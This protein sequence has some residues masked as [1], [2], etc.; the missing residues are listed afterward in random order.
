ME[1]S[2]SSMVKLTASNYSIWKTR[3]EDVLYCKDLFDPIEM[4]GVKP[5]S[6]TNEDWNKMNRKAVGYI[7]QW[8]D[9]SVFHHVAK[10]VDAYS[11]WQK[12]ESLYERKTAQNKAFVIRRLVNLKYKDGHSV[13]EHLSN[14]QGLLNDLSTMKLA[15]DDEVQAL[16]LLSSLPDSWETLV[17]SLSNSAPSGV[18]TMSMVKDSMFNE[19]ARRKEQGI[20]SQSEALVTEK[21]GRSKSRKPRKYDSRD[22]SKGK[23]CSRSDIKCFFCGKLGHM[24]REC[25][26]FKKEQLK[27]KGEEQKEEKDTAAVA[28][29]GDVVIAFDE[30]YAN[31][32]CDESRWVVDTAA[33]F[34][35]TPHRDFFSSY[36]NGHFGWV[37]M[38]NEAKCKIVGMGD[39]QLET[40]IGCKLVLK[41]VRHVPEMRFNLISIWKLDD[42]GYHNY[43]GGGQWKLSKGSLSLAKGKK[44]SSLYKTDARLVKGDAVVVENENSTELWHKRLGHM[45]E[46][47]LQILAKEQLLPNNKGMSLTPCTHCLIGKQRRVS[48]Q[49]SSSSRKENILDLVHTDVCTMNTKTLG[50]ALYYV[51][52]IDDHSRKVWV[53]A[54]KTKDQVLDVFKVFHMKVERETGKQLKCVRAD[55]GGEYRGPF[56]EYCRSHGIRLEKT[57]PKTPQHN[58]VAERMNRT[59]CE[60]IRCMLS[61]AKLP[62]PFWG[63]AMRTAVDLINLSPSV[64]LD[65]D[66]P[67]RVWTGKDVSFEHL[68]VFGCRAFVHIPRDERSK[69]DSKVKQ[70]IFMGYGHEEFGYRLWDPVNKKIIR[71][72]DVVFFE[73]QTIE[74]LDQKKEESL[75]KYCVDLGPVVPTYVMHD[76]H[77][78]DVQ[79]EHVDTVGENGEPTIDNVESEEH[80]EQASSEPTTETQLRRSTRDRQPSRKYSANEYVLLSDRGEPE[81]YQDAMQ[82]D[83]KKQWLEA[84]QD[85]MK[86]LHENHTY[87]LVKLPKGKRAL[88][89]K[90][91]FRCKIEPN[92]SQP[93]YKARLVVKGFSQKKGIDFDEIFSPVVKMSSIRVVLS[94]AA[95]MNL[96]IE[97]LDV[98]TAFLHGDLEEEIYMEQPEGFSAKGKEHL[99]C[100]LK[101][102]LYG[103]KQ[104]PRLWYKKFDSFMVDHGYDRTTS[105]HC[106][107][108]KKFSDGEFIILLLYVDDMLIVGRDTSKIDKLKKELSKSFS[109]KDLGSAK[110][111]LGMKISRD[112]KSEKLWLS[113]ES[114]IEKVLDRFNMSKAK[115]VSSTLAGHLKLSS[116]QS[117]TSEEE[118]EEMK[119][120]PYASAVGSLMYAMVCTRPDIAHAVGVV[121]RFL[122][123]P[124]KEHWAAV[125]WILRYLRGTSRVCLCFGNGKQVLDGFT[126]ADMAGDIDS[127]KST[128]GYLITYSGGAVSWQSRL[129]KCVALST[130]EAEYIAITEAAKELL[131]MKKFLQELGLQQERYVLYC[132]SQSAIHLSKNSTFH[133]RSKHIDVRYHWI[134]DALDE[135]LIH[136]EKIHTDDNGSDMMTKSLPMQKL[137]ICRI[138]AGLV[139]P[140]T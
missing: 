58:G 6:T 28:L 59:I 7:R 2:S 5:I 118:K 34:H 116:K 39:I 86:S 89:N 117:P 50:G 132:D 104:A 139:E 22:K 61:H 1:E 77:T 64:P 72:R 38:G 57:V 129:Q 32:T 67:Q 80:L 137:E 23:S 100:R 96:E 109:M 3:M 63:E 36:T 17:V 13:T 84:M 102:S 79:E 21:R 41:D 127:R 101:K 14:F 25:R 16:L 128:S 91:V 66:I 51:T 55:N 131:W 120:V 31:I 97:Q 135:K 71:S 19:E 48:F 140:P 69:L 56:E 54:L 136:I 43:L 88:K 29:D 114:Y 52:F 62:K 26:K 93:R 94:L 10:E 138:A 78:G 65:G 87:D 107:F 12:L 18:I 76:E 95:K 35:I 110:Q 130:T 105:D 37:R 108:V 82:H 8:I 27:E 49:K 40:D 103:L 9:Q 106:V 90:W 46:K 75:N 123:N 126:D 133:S 45:S 74:D 30:A 85:E 73:D 11:L 42:E 125:K 115:P 81:S 121:S 124:G 24:K 4:E 98:K 47:G 20:S 44:I 53:F 112:R 122:S 68:R 92:R 60:R 134:R 15:L 33:S 111:I 70:C 83:Q 113:Q 99:V 119:K